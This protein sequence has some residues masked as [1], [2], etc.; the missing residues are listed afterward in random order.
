VVETAPAVA[1]T[2]RAIRTE[3]RRTAIRFTLGRGPFF[4]QPPTG[5][6]DGLGR[7]ARPSAELC[8]FT[9]RFVVPRFVCTIRRWPARS[10]RGWA[11]GG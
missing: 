8:G 6:A 1:T 7:E 2:S 11:D 9:P 4:P 3:V 10:A 5:L